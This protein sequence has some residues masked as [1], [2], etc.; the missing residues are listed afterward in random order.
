MLVCVSFVYNKEV[1]QDISTVVSKEHTWSPV[2]LPNSMLCLQLCA[3]S[4][5][6]CSFLTCL[7]IIHP[8]KLLLFWW[9]LPSVSTLL[10]ALLCT[11]VKAGSPL[12]TS[13]SY[14]DFS[15]PSGSY[16]VCLKQEFLHAHLKVFSSP[17]T[18]PFIITGSKMLLN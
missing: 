13:S 5:F 3:H 14:L 15:Q 10:E 16:M 18:L 8:Q 4:V 9:S 7:R 11:D 6:L 2:G 17:G 1:D 12:T